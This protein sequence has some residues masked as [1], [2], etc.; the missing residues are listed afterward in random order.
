MIGAN[1][2]VTERDEAE[3]ARE[4]LVEELNHRVKN[5]LSVVQAIAHQTF[6]KN[7][8]ASEAR[9]AFEGRLIALG[10]AHDLL[11]HANWENA[12]LTE[13]AEVT[14]DTRGANRDS[15][16]LTGPRFLL[17][18]KQAVSLAMAFHELCTNARK[19][20][21]LSSDNGRV[22]VEWSRTEGLHP[23]LRI[24]WRESGGPLVSMPSRR[25]FGSTLL[26]RTLARDLNGEVTV[27]FKSLG[28]QCTIALPLDQSQAGARGDG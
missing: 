11:T 2:D 10:Q 25:G 22:R 21:A 6:S 27:N 5:T 13:L 3:K 26:E 9:R 19:Y 1:V 8:D 14:L 20:G 4:L 12:S 24:R 17:S 7:A 16:S 18:P 15:I 28:L 23:Y